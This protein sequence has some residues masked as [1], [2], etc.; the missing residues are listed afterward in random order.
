MFWSFFIIFTRHA[1]LANKKSMLVW[2]ELS[3]T[4]NLTIVE[5]PTLSNHI[6]GS[7]RPETMISSWTL[8]VS[9]NI[10]EIPHNEPSGAAALSDFR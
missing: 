2:E 1:L 9:R 3:D 6:I 10:K 5:I 7:S 4:I 8:E